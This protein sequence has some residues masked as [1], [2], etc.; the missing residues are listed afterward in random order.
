MDIFYIHHCNCLLEMTRLLSSDSCV[1]VINCSVSTKFLE[2]ISFSLLDIIN[3]SIMTLKF[4][5][6]FPISPKVWY[7]RSLKKKTSTSLIIHFNI[8]IDNW[9]KYHCS[10]YFFDIG[11]ERYSKCFKY[12]LFLIIRK[13]F[14]TWCCTIIFIIN[15]LYW[16]ITIF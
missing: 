12:I 15:C 3:I 13:I 9:W 11:I 8:L 10:W 1:E 4:K 2:Y 14:Y 5:H 6:L 16:F 7:H